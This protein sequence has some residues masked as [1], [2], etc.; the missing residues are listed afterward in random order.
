MPATSP[1]PSLLHI[2]LAERD[3]EQQQQQ[4]VY[5]IESV[6]PIVIWI[7]LAISPYAI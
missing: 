1:L 5:S 7:G 6:L 2:L 3:E 4:R